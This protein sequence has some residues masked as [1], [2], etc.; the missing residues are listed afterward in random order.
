[1]QGMH[2]MSI[3]NGVVQDCYGG[4]SDRSPM[5][6]LQNFIYDDYSYIKGGSEKRRQVKRNF[7]RV[8]IGLFCRFQCLWTQKICEILWVIIK[9]L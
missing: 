6:E 4:E 8:R 3:F 5:S 1:M 7:S 2:A 9:K